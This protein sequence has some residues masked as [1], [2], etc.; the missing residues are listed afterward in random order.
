MFFS[1]DISYPKKPS[2]ECMTD[3]KG[4]T[5]YKLVSLYPYPL[6]S[7]SCYIC[8]E[9]I[10]CNK[11]KLLIVSTLPRSW[12]AIQQPITSSIIEHMVGFVRR[13][14][15]AHSPSA[16]DS[17]TFKFSYTETS[18]AVH[19]RRYFVELY[20]YITYCVSEN[21]VSWTVALV[22]SVWKLGY[23]RWL[24]LFSLCVA[25]SKLSW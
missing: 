25:I 21:K 5:R 13:R 14:L 20:S 17:L 16:L 18:K 6:H 23:W 24:S 3:T 1:I 4:T 10:R 22:R 8:R 15:H 12:I 19:M 9:T 2:T 7:F 11:I